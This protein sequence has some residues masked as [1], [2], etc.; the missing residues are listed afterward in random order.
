MAVSRKKRCMHR[1]T[2]LPGHRTAQ[3]KY[4]KGREGQQ[5]KGSKGKVTR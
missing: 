2:C 3:G 4:Q 5:R 1:K